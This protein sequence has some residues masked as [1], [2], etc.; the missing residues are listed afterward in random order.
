MAIELVGLFVGMCP[1]GLEN[2]GIPMIT[3]I[4]D[5]GF[6]TSGIFSSFL[7]SFYNV[8]EGYYMNLRMPV[9]FAWIY[10]DMA[11]LLSSLFLI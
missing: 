1:D 5:T 3:S 4:V 2:T 6:L 9:T 7:L 11:M 8:Q 10:G